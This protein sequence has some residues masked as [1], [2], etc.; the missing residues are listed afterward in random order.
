MQTSNESQIAQIESA[1]LS[2]NS[3]TP[4]EAIAET[5]NRVE[6]LVSK[7]REVK[8]QLDDALLERLTSGDGPREITIGT[9]KYYVAAR[10]KVKCIDQEAALLALLDHTGG[11][12]TKLADCLSANGLKHGACRTVLG[13]EY[14][15][16]FETITE[17]DVKTGQPKKQVKADN[18]FMHKHKGGKNH[19]AQ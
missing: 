1:V 6:W 9:V 8:K 2:I 12:L 7:A 17:I 4:T 13:D 5:I 10:S 11:D 16:H 3:D 15:A 14:D 19:A 18:G